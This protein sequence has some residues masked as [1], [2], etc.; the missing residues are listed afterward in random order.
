MDL[1]HNINKVHGDLLNNFNDVKIVEK[2][3]LEMNNYFEL[4]V[5]ENNKELK[6]IIRKNDIENNIFNWKYYSNPLNMD[7][8]LIERVS[9]IG[10]FY[11]DVKDILEKNRF[12]EDYLKEI[13]K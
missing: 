10:N 1:K 3:S 9:S 5:L 7:S 13:N 6:L 8:Y 11:N 12:N 2:S 4:S